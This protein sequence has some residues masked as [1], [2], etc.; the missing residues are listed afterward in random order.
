MANPSFDSS[1]VS[2]S[3]EAVVVNHC[4]DDVGV[5]LGQF[6]EF[7]VG[8][9]SQV[10]HLKADSHIDALND[11]PKFKRRKVSGRIAQKL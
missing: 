1:F 8:V 4:T 7:I 6:L 9:S 3:F 2:D 10:D 5:I 11:T